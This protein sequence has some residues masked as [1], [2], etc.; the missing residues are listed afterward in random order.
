MT[1]EW[2]PRER[3]PLRYS[4]LSPHSAI[5]DRIKVEQHYGGNWSAFARR[6]KIFLCFPSPAAWTPIIV[7]LG[8]CVSS[9]LSGISLWL[10]VY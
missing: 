4:H 2:P 1:A 6:Y 3:T 5:T 10:A 8:S 9:A 7:A